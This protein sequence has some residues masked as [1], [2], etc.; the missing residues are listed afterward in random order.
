MYRLLSKEQICDYI[1]VYPTQ[2]KKTK[3]ITERYM[4]MENFQDVLTSPNIHNVINL[5]FNK[6]VNKKQKEL[7]MSMINTAIN[8]SSISP[9]VKIDTSEN[10]MRLG[11][12]LRQCDL[13]D[14]YTFDEAMI[15]LKYNT[16][17]SQKAVS[18]SQKQSEDMQKVLRE[19]GLRD[20][21]FTVSSG[22]ATDY[23]FTTD[24]GEVKADFI[25]EKYGIVGFLRYGTS[26]GGSQNDRHRG[27]ISLARSYPDTRFIF[28][29]DGTESFLQHSLYNHIDDIHNAIWSTIEL[30]P[31]I[32]FD[33][34][35]LNL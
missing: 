26:S 17:K 34:L 24:K 11:K 1:T 25:I 8:Y 14:I 2:L 18:V 29:N 28:I 19:C 10:R 31:H 5:L 21:E 4:N 13:Q 33:N 15:I 32:D 7:M 23:V 3:L 22:G 12:I 27:M 35:T 16:Q 9:L 20:N 6:T 30:V